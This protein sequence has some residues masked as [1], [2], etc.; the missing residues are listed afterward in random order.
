MQLVKSHY[1]SVITEEHLKLIFIIGNT[2]LEHHL[3]EM[4]FLLQKKIIPFFSFVNLYYE[5]T[6]QGRCGSY[7]LHPSTF[8]LSYLLNHGPRKIILEN[9]NSV[10]KNIKTEKLHSYPSL[11]LTIINCLLISPTERRLCGEAG[12]GKEKKGGRE[13]EEKVR[14]KER[15]REKQRQRGE[16]IFLITELFLISC[17]EFLPPSLSSMVQF[18]KPSG[19]SPESEALPWSIVLFS[20]RTT[21]KFMITNRGG[22]RGVFTLIPMGETGHGKRPMKAEW[23]GMAV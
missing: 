12:R 23:S 5:W 22:F 11:Q 9:L 4:L 2:N 1:R 17:L 13:E 7:W 20:I 3:S 8:S 19:S 14:E 16:T 21:L 15:E 10:D 6:K 18:K